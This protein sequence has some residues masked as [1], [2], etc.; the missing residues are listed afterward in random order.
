MSDCKCSGGGCK[1]TVDLSPA[2]EKGMV[3]NS[4]NNF[5]ID[6]ETNYS[7]VDSLIEINEVK[8]D[9]NFKN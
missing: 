5:N 1:C 2:K 8:P 7:D 4:Y 6:F 3:V 9:V